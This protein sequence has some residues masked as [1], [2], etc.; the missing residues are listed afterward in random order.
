MRGFLVPNLDTYD[1]HG[2]I[3]SRMFNFNLLALRPM[4]ANDLCIY[5]YMLAHADPVLQVADPRRYAVNDLP[6]TSTTFQC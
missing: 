2:M 4:F 1:F 6:Q 5:R 3:K